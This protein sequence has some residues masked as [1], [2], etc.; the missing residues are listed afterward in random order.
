MNDI[1]AAIGLVQLAKLEQMNQKRFKISNVYT[2]ELSGIGDIQVPVRK[3]FV[4]KP[5]CHNYVIKTSQRNKLNEFLAKKG[6]STGVHYIPNN[7]YKMYKSFKGQ[8]PIAHRVWKNILTLPLY[9]DLKS[10]E[11][12][13]I[14]QSIKEFYC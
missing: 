3:S 13:Y 6:I 4:T 5:S 9:P 11:V 1:N 8:T 7:L 2:K 12:D 10:N 14:I